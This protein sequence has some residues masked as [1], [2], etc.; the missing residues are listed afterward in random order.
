MYRTSL[1]CRLENS[2][3]QE[4]EEN[5]CGVREYWTRTHRLDSLLVNYVE[6]NELSLSF[7]CYTQEIFTNSHLIFDFLLLLCFFWVWEICFTVTSLLEAVFMCL[8]YE[9][10][11]KTDPNRNSIYPITMYKASFSLGWNM[12]SCP[13]SVKIRMKMYTI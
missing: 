8:V 13:A 10:T 11:I 3:T 6:G 2:N 5:Q 1:C 12:D 7:S 4:T 9:C